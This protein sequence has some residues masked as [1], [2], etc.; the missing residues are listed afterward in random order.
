ME[1]LDPIDLMCFA[2]LVELALLCPYAWGDPLLPW[3]RKNEDA[4]NSRVQ[5]LH[6]PGGE[7]RAGIDRL[8]GV[9]I[10]VCL[11]IFAFEVFEDVMT[12]SYYAADLRSHR[13]AGCYSAIEMLIGVSGPPNGLY[14]LGE[15]MLAYAL[16]VLAVRSFLVLNTN[17]LSPAHNREVPFH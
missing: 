1:T 6:H 12:L 4:A 15:L 9:L 11:L 10:S 16:V 17:W 3:R 7:D 5:V 14:R 2:L 8:K 13:P